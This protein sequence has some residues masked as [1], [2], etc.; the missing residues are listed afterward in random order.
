M[1][2]YLALKRTHRMA[3]RA[4]IT[5]VWEDPATAERRYSVLL[6]RLAKYLAMPFLTPDGLTALT[7]RQSPDDDDL[8]VVVDFTE[9]WGDLDRPD[10]WPRPDR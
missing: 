7:W 3:V 8:I 1:A 6:D 2:E 9:P 10:V 4:A 5:V